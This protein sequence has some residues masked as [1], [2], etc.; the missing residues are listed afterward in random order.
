LSSYKYVRI[1]I[2]LTCETHLHDRIISL[3]EEPIK[4]V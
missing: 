4:L 3:R 1:G 2:L